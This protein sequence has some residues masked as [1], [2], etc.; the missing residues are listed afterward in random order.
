MHAVHGRSHLDSGA[1]YEEG[2][3]TWHC[4]LERQGGAIDL[5]LEPE[6]SVLSPAQDTSLMYDVRR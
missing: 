2:F 4:L 3:P 1:W 5:T 6:K